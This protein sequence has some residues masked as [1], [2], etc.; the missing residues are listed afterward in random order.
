MQRDPSAAVK[1]TTLDGHRLRVRAFVEHCGDVPLESVTFEW[2]STGIHFMGFNMWMA[3]L[4]TAPQ[5]GGCFHRM[6]GFMP[7][8]QTSSPL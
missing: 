8:I 5:A 1:A 6:V 3:G 2:V 7:A 4:T